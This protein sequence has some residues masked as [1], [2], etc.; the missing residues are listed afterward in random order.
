[1]YSTSATVVYATNVFTTSIL[2]LYFRQRKT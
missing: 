2:D 1:V